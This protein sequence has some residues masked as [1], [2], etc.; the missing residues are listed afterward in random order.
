MKLIAL[1]RPEVANHPWACMS[2]FA[3]TVFA[4]IAIARLMIGKK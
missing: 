2:M 4:I 1:V 3:V